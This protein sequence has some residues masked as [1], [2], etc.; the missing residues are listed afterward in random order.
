MSRFLLLI[1]LTVSVQFTQ[2]QCLPVT[3]FDYSNYTGTSAEI[4]WTPAGTE[5]AWVIEYGVHPYNPA[6]NSGVIIFS[7]GSPILAVTGLTSNVA[8]DF[9]ISADCQNLGTS[10]QTGPVIVPSNSINGRIIYDSDSNGCSTTDPMVSGMRINAQ[11]TS[12]SSLYSAITD[13]NGNYEILVPSGN[14]TLDMD[15]NNSIVSVN[16][17]S[18][19]ISFPNSSNNFTQDFCIV[20]ITLQQD[21]VVRIIPINQARPGFD[22][23]Y[24]VIVSNQGTLP[25]SD[26]LKFS[27]NNTLMTFLSALPTQD[28]TTAN[29]IFW[30]YTLNPFESNTYRVTINLNAPTH[31][32]NPLNGGDI[33]LPNASSYLNSADVDLSNNFYVLD[34]TVVNSYDPNDKTCLQGNT[35][36]PDMIGEYLE[37]LIRFENTGT[38]SAINVRVKDVIDTAKFDIDSFVPLNSS[39][40][41]YT[42]I[43]NGNEVEFHFDDINLDF[44]DATNDGYVLFKIKTL[45]SL[46]VGDSFD[47]T[48]EIFFDFNFP[49]ITNTE[50]VTILSTA[51]I[52][53]RSENSIV[54]SP[55]PSHDFI[56]LDASFTID[57]LLIYDLQGRMQSQ[58]DVSTTDF[59]APIFISKLNPGVYFMVVKSDQGQETLKFIKN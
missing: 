59:E 51:S 8:Y 58:Y 55:N 10:V 4:Y 14:F 22:V 13:S 40:E 38:A 33:I 1:L 34:Q 11:A 54:L 36:E 3:Q 20:P 2:S 47:N 42:R 23:M 17:Q 44:N 29:S 24:D 37:Y 7:T 35:I 16:P 43:T 39:H 45:N 46:A 49:I 31:P 27:Y 50:T 5:T 9:F 18:T 57:S 28:N 6:T 41:Y 15:F 53:D 52:A 25:V 12:V 21:I 30:N 48:A 19:N 26:V 32:T 56:S